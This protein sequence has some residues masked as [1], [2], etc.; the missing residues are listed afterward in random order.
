MAVFYAVN[1]NMIFVFLGTLTTQMQALMRD[2]KAYME[3]STT[4]LHIMDAAA[5]NSTISLPKMIRV[6]VVVGYVVFIV[7]AISVS[8]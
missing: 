7:F 5:F 1:C 6:S 8:L 4:A 3:T 2:A